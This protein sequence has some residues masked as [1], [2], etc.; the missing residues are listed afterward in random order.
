MA[1]GD[2]YRI[3]TDLTMVGRWNHDVTVH[4]LGHRPSHMLS[5]LSQSPP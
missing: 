3:R 5:Q 2:R 1:A 4:G